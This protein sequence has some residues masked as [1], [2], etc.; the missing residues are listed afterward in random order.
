MYINEMS[1]KTGLTKKAI[2]YY[3]QKGLVSPSV[4]ENGYRD[5]SLDDLE[6]LSK[7]AILRKLGAGTEDIRAVLSENGRAALQKLTLQKELNLHREEAKKQLLDQL[8]SGKSYLEINED[9]QV[10]DNNKT[11]TERLLDAFPGYFGRYVTLHFSRFLNEPIKTR[12]QQTAYDTI[13]T[14][15]DD[16]PPFSIPDDL[17][18]YFEEGTKHIG[19]TEINTMLENVQHSIE[20]PEEFLTDKKEFIEKYLKFKQSDEYKSS[21]AYRLMELTKTIF[22]TNGYYD[23]F[24]PALKELS[25]SYAEYS[26]QMEAANQK[27]LAEYPEM[28]SL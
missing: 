19:T 9:L 18:E 6:S 15:L 10:I 14:F 27:L 1:K 13:L 2:E 22:S 17:Q 21:P 5:Y 4:L 16:M 8:S 20:E 24:I 23:V 3:T 25:S 26:E 11:I 28:G 12:T 7:I